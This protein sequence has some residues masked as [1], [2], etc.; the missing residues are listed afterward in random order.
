[1][2]P[3]SESSGNGLGARQDQ[4]HL[5]IGWPQHTSE[6]GAISPQIASCARQPTSFLR[7][8]CDKRNFCAIVSLLRSSSSFLNREAKQDATGCWFFQRSAAAANEVLR[9][10]ERQAVIARSGA[11]QAEASCTDCKN[12]VIVLGLA[13]DVD[14]GL[15]RMGGLSKMTSQ[16]GCGQPSMQCKLNRSCR[17]EV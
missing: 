7:P 16:P 15:T 13:G 2:T 14:S 8:P 4:G 17:W 11:N 1:M 12:C 10:V 9:G 3:A 6:A 5:Y